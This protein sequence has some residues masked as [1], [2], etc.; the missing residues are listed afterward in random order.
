G[1]SRGVLL[2][3]VWLDRRGLGPFR[4]RETAYGWGCVFDKL[5][6]DRVR[7]RLQQLQQVATPMP[8][9]NTSPAP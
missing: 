5:V 6:L 8:S 7:Q 4:Q 1:I 9:P 2:T 3:A